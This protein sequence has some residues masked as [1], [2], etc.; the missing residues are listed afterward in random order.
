ME[1]ANRPVDAVWPADAV[2]RVGDDQAVEGV[3]ALAGTRARPLDDR[4]LLRVPP[5]AGPQR[6]LPAADHGSFQLHHDPSPRL[7][8][9]TI[10]QK[11]VN[12]RSF[13]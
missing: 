10:V 9:R 7:L 12:V 6:C 11:V 1:A 2:A 4:R 8:V 3:A 5:V 13:V